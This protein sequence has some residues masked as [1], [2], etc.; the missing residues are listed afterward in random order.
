MVLD[1]VSASR[2]SSDLRVGDLRIYNINMQ[3]QEDK[4]RGEIWGLCLEF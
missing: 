2:N 3:I 1:F 4:V